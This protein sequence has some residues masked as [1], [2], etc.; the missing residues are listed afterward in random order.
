[1]STWRASGALL[2]L[3]AAATPVDAQRTVEITGDRLTGFVLP[4]E[5]AETGDTGIRIT[6]LR[7]WAWSVDDT[8]RLL[9]EGG[10][11]VQVGGYDIAGD[12]AV[13][14]LNRIPSAQGLI[15]Q[16]AVYFTHVRNPASRSGVSISGTGVLLTASARGPVMLDVARLQRH[17]PPNSEMLTRAE[18]RL[19]ASLKRLLRE[20]PPVLNQRPQLDRSRPEPPAEP[21]PGGAV[22]PPPPAP[23]AGPHRVPLPDDR[24]GTP[25]LFAATGTVWFSWGEL[26]VSSGEQENV[27]TATGSIVVQYVVG[28]DAGNGQDGQDA[29]RWSELTMTARRVVV[30]ADPGPLD[31][32]LSGRV[33]ADTIRGIYLEGNVVATTGG[34]EYTLRAPQMYYDFDSGQAIMVEAVLRTY[35]RQLGAPIFARARELRQIAANQWTADRAIVSTS[36]FF[37]PHLAIGA[38]RVTM[39]E[40]PG[41][42]GGDST[43]FIESSHN[44][45]EVGGVPLLYWPKFAGTM[46]DVPLQGLDVGSRSSD[47]VRVLTRWDPFALLGVERPAGV[48]A[49]LR[50][51]VF[52]KRGGGGGIDLTYDTSWGL[53]TVDL[54]YLHD[55]GTDRTSS[56][57]DVTPSNQNRGVALLSHQQ[58]LGKNWLFQ[59]QL[60]LISDETFI[61]TWRD[62]DYANRREYE[63]SGYLRHTAE[64][65]ALDF[66]VRF[67]ANDFISNSYLLASRGYQVDKLPELTYRRYGD[68]IFNDQV[69]YSGE[70]RLSRLKFSF[71]EGTPRE[72]GV[73]PGAFAPAVGIDDSISGAFAAA[74]FPTGYVT[75]FDTRHEFALPIKAG[76]V[77]IVPY[78]VGRLTAYSDD[79]ESFSSDAADTR[80][81]GAVGIRLNTQFQRVD[82]T[83]ESSLFD[84]HRLR[85]IVE[86]RLT[87]W[88]GVSDVPDGALP[89]Y[90]EAVESIGGA[91]V[92]QVGLNTT[93]QTQRGG[94]GRWRSVD[95][96]TVDAS[97]VLNSGDANTE[98]PTPQF[99]EYRP[100][101]SQFGDHVFGSFVWALSDHLD[102][103]GQATYDI[104]GSELARASIGTHLQHSPL[105]STFIEFRLIEADD[106]RLMGIGWRYKLTNKY[107]VA[108]TPQW[109]FVA[110]E[111]RAVSLAIVRSFPDVDLSIRVRRDE[112]ADETTIGVSLG[113]VEF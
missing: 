79:F 92:I 55:T 17:P 78:M 8:R 107:R 4:V 83:V 27:I 101:Y 68:S 42:D 54:Y 37:T 61:T 59:G 87:A 67:D 110:N 63:T 36:E 62:E 105:F 33:D 39:T 50:A 32:L 112:I 65:A 76:A 23:D 29:D 57:L 56:G 12:E 26:H 53:G 69:T 88:Y 81:F 97:V 90:D 60:S 28:G 1:M 71:Q 18:R 19:A 85:T 15:N 93:F 91:S 11:R 31:S 77:K 99:F 41:T 14:W 9:L 2:A 95:V 74:G 104:D 13:V 38:R 7:A 82:N 49:E 52:T 103:V 94:P 22:V 102:V 84:L 34:G 44:T 98:S 108:L 24:A 25:P 75:R 46:Q 10:V 66:L 58:A 64:N 109:D 48:N 43:L 51:D 106:T 35:S 73:R 6:A 3:L 30:F 113:L 70:T 16:L 47:G 45:L 86:P 5:P 96:L 80:A 40:R 21:R 20:P 100:E 89:V 111:F 72:A